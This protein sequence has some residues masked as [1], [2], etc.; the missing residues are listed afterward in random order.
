M[1]LFKQKK[2]AVRISIL[3]TIITIT[4]LLFLWI[5]V[6]V[7]SATMVK[8]NI[9]N[10]MID[11]VESRAAIIDDYVT[12]AEEYLAAFSL[13]SDVRNL[14]SNPNDPTLLEKAQNYTKEFANIK[15][16]FEGL[17]IGTPDTY[18]L[19]HTSPD[20]IGMTTR[21][22]DS[23][24]WFQQN[25]LTTKKITNLGIMV[26]PGTGNM[27]L[28]MYYP[29]FQDQHCIGYVGAGVFANKLMD[30]LIELNIEGLPN[31]EYVFL[32]A[33]TGVYLYNQDE[34][35]LNTETTDVGYKEIIKRIKEDSNTQPGT[36]TY[37][38]ENN[39]TQ[40]V[41]YKYLQDRNW[42]FMV[43]D[44]ASEVYGTV[45][46]IRILMGI[47]CI[48]IA[49]T[50]ILI[51]IFVLRKI[52]KELMIVENAI[53]RLG[54]LDLSADRDL[55]QFYCR[56]DEI[57]IIAKTTNY[58]CEHLRMTI[59]DIAR[60]LGEL[61]EGNLSV[62]VAKNESYYVGDFKALSDSLKTVSVKLIKL[63]RDVAAVSKNV[64]SEAEQV[65]KDT[66]A[67]S[68]GT[69]EQATSV[70]SLITNIQD[71]TTQIQ[72]NAENCASA[73]KL[74]DQT[75][76]YT[77]EADG[78]MSQLTKA[79]ET[80]DNSSKEIGNIVKTIDDIAF[81]TNILA[82]NASIEAARVGDSGKGFAVVAEE[83]RML[84]IKSAEAAK[85]TASLINHSLNDVKA[86][87][88][89]ANQAASIMKIIDN[90]TESIKSLMDEIA[91]SSTQQSNMTTM[92]DKGINDI[93]RVVQT[94]SDAV[95]QSAYT[96][97]EL[98]EQAA[99]LNELLEHFRI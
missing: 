26:S 84:A 15:G 83:I 1:G 16:I 74:V 10:Q 72:N 20:A 51:T 50:I 86:G 75:A 54:K 73:S 43:R 29:I 17:Y 77:A 78:K 59:N 58:L 4:G 31:K 96:S 24:K 45:T 9:T 46:I 30:S 66:F 56:E 5:I 23:L 7:N 35:L 98:S 6:A 81:Q 62:N 53:D 70:V 80:L 8:V 76:V 64:T 99:N 67:L 94:N 37:Q 19:T 36:Y 90:Y 61:A 33:E 47:A 71:I 91:A 85:N 44:N 79:M 63:M 88:E 28:S 34:A 87:T 92:V 32:N 93:S 25:I 68:Q 27:I 12:S 55:G 57:G 89:A 52:G 14:L 60:I 97:Q 48:V 82:V 95:E 11:A 41:V 65:S 69:M 2:L 49:T 3:T 40:L 42:V 22:G 21:Q 18:I 13:S 39:I 38:D